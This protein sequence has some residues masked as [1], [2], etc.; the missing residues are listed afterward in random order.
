MEQYY[1]IP[2]W[3]AHE[4]HIAHWQN[5]DGPNTPLQI[6]PKDYFKYWWSTTQDNNT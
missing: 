5:I 2:F 1:F 4:D 6:K 3:H